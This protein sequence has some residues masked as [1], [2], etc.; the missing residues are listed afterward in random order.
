MRMMLSGELDKQAQSTGAKDMAKFTSASAAGC[1]SKD[2][3]AWGLKPIAYKAR[4]PSL[5]EHQT[6][7]D[8]ILTADKARMP[9]PCEGKTAFRGFSN[10]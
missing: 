10:C 7:W 3:T 6:A 1:P 4:M 5:S 2:Q 8:L 9:S